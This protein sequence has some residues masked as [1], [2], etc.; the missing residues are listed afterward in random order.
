MLIFKH[1]TVIFLS[2]ILRY[3]LF[4]MFLMGLIGA[5][6]FNLSHPNSEYELS[7]GMEDMFDVPNDDLEM[8]D[9]IT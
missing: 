4:I 2:L 6:W 1:P 9:G 3:A 5:V 8:L 7:T